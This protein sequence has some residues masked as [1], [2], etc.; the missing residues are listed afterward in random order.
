MP[1][2][3]LSEQASR[4]IDAAYT[5]WA[6]NRSVEQASRW[7]LGIVQRLLVLEKSPELCP[8]APEDRFLPYVLRQILF[9]L[10]SRPTH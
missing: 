6:E 4:D 8:L 9:G 1:E 10:G 2:V 3:V 5:W 7:Y